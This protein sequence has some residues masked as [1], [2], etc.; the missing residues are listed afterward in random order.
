M[1]RLPKIEIEFYADK[2]GC[3]QKGINLKWDGR[4]WLKFDELDQ[5]QVEMIYDRVKKDSRAERAF[6]QLH[7]HNGMN[8][9]R[10]IL[11]QFILCNWTTLDQK[12]DISSEK[13][14]FENVPCPF[15]SNDKCPY[16]RGIVCIKSK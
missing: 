11:H 10:D 13:L 4:E 2:T 16:G 12:L 15:K 3:F 7:N 9:K 5:L 1:S 8:N 14:N 6:W